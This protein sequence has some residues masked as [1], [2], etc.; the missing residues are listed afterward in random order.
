[1]PKRVAIFVLLQYFLLGGCASLTNQNLH[2]P[3]TVAA[4]AT[5]G[6]T[7]GAAIGSFLGKPGA[8]LGAAAGAIIGGATGLFFT[9]NDTN[10]EPVQG[11]SASDVNTLPKTVHNNDLSLADVEK[12]TLKPEDVDL[13]GIDDPIL[14][15]D[16]EDQEVGYPTPAI[17]LCGLGTQITRFPRLARNGAQRCRTI[18]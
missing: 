7:A 10:F 12:P 16:S 9:K 1:M 15:E 14:E 11:S 4:T 13:S 8:I 18:L 5:V 17:S 2:R 3:I 6:A